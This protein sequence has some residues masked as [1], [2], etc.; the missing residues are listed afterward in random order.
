M[1]RPTIP[2]IPR[3]RPQWNPDAK[4]PPAPMSVAQKNQIANNQRAAERA[5][6][7]KQELHSTR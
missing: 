5:N 6:Q 2:P 4:T 7:L 1:S 3:Q